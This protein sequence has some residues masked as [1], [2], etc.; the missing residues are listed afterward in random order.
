MVIVAQATD[1][2]EVATRWARPGLLVANCTIGANQQ[3][4]IWLRSWALIGDMSAYNAG[5]R[6]H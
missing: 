3:A 2:S 6:G 4:G 1:W 5:S